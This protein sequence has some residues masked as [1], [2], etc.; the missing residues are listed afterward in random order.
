[1]NTLV[2][3]W[4]E[5]STVCNPSNAGSPTQLTG[6][7]TLL[8]MQ[9]GGSVGSDSG[10]DA[11]FLRLNTT[12]PAGAY[13]AGWD[14]SSLANSTPITGIHH[15]AADVKKVSQG[16]KYISHNNTQRVS[17]SSGT[18]EQGS[19]GSALFSYDSNGYYLRGGLFGGAASCSNSGGSAASGNSD[20]YSRFDVVY[21]NLTAW[22][23]PAPVVGPTVSH[24][25]PW[26]NPAE[27]GWGLTWFDDYSGGNY[28]GLM[29]IYT[30]TGQ[31]D[32]YEFAGA[33]TG[34]DI[35]SGNIRKNTGPAFGTTFDPAQV[36]K[37]PVGTYTL[38]FT[39]ATSATLTFTIGGVT[40]TNIPLTKL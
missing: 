39:S 1:A 40:R 10:T 34:S 21:P 28:F 19:S 23:T 22:L 12:P 25:G 32:W 2:T 33:W 38:T 4:N 9:S 35:H 11:T 15:P 36:T 13:F 16:T 20:I 30:G 14:S 37:T 17:W 26:Y 18:T 8:Y 27:S 3:F 24:T 5:E 6:G 31:P 7:A 29:F